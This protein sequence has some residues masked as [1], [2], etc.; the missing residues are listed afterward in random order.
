MS[1]L[2]FHFESNQVRAHVDEFGDPWWVVADI[3]RALGISN[4][5]DAASR[6][7]DEWRGVGKTDT[8]SGM[9]EMVT[10]N[11]PGLYQL[12]FRS[13]KPEAERFRQWVFEDVLP[14]IRATGS[15]VAVEAESHVKVDQPVLEVET[16]FPSGR[17]EIVRYA[18]HPTPRYRARSAPTEAD[19]HSTADVEVLRGRFDKAL[20]RAMSA[21]AREMRASSDEFGALIAGVNLRLK[22]AV[23]RPREEWNASDF[24]L[25][26]DYLSVNYDFDVQL[27]LP[28]A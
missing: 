18:T 1:E 16:R 23:G 2:K 24:E 13:N 3:C 6:L 11:E 12:I 4:H 17:V 8:P 21:R 19:R 9:Q 7:P 22:N 25:A 27:Q 28:A 14:S 10:C 15:Y 26:L 5:R 20:K